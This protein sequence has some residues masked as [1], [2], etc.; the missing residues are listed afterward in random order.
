[1][2]R[3]THL[4]KDTMPPKAALD[5]ARLVLGAPIVFERAGFAP[6][7]PVDFCEVTLCQPVILRKAG[8]REAGRDRQRRGGLE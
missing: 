2:A 7:R 8:V 1:M 3:G 6:D 5:A 4:G